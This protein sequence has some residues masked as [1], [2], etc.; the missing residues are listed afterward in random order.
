MSMTTFEK[1][2]YRIA[3]MRAEMHEL[4]ATAHD[5]ELK[6]EV[7]DYQIMKLNDILQTMDVPKAEKPLESNEE[8]C[9]RLSIKENNDA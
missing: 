9:R 5:A 7:L 6:A 4:R 8:L 2:K 3:C 1:L